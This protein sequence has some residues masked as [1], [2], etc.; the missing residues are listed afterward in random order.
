MVYDPRQDE[1]FNK[2]KLFM[3]LLK[4]ESKF[5]PNAVSPTGARGYAQ[6][7]KSTAAD[8]GFGLTPNANAINDPKQNVEF[9]HAYL[10]ML[11]KRY[12]GD[13]QAAA[14][15][16][17]GG[18]GA[19]DKWVASGKNDKVISKEAS[20]YY[21]I[22]ADGK[23]KVDIS[24]KVSKIP[25]D[26]EYEPQFD[27]VLRKQGK[28]NDRSTEET[29][30]LKAEPPVESPDN[31]LGVDST[32]NTTP[33]VKEST[34]TSSDSDDSTGASEVSIDPSDFGKVAKPL[35]LSEFTT[36]VPFA[37]KLTRIDLS[38]LD[39]PRLR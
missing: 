30:K 23:D 37:P 9:G 18:P 29:G 14:V 2:D 6:I 35:Q 27:K 4:Q 8:P 20:N 12:K 15:G 17:N 33:R 10:Q 22:V 13:A 24:K 31:A 11:L 21:K 19:A 32:T 39:D 7:L 5:N 38:Q 36:T 34:N 1:R 3:S 25:E 28:S 26:P 16:Y